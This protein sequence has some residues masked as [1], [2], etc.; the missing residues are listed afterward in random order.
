MRAFIYLKN[1]KIQINQRNVYFLFGYWLEQT[2]CNKHTKIKQ[3]NKKQRK[4]KTNKK[5]TCSYTIREME[6]V[7][8]KVRNNF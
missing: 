5:T 6:W 4:T 2:N 8:C 7:L 3:T 1:P